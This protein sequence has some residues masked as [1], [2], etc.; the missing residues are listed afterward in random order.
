MVIRETFN[1]L[2]KTIGEIPF[3]VLKIRDTLKLIGHDA[4]RII[5]K[6]L[7]TILTS[8]TD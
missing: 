7:A 8:E 3:V 2:A 5:F 6:P 4:A 1:P